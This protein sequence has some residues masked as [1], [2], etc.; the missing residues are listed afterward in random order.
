MSSVASITVQAT[1]DPNMKVYHTRFEMSSGP[2]AGSRGDD[3]QV[4]GFGQLVLAIQ[5][6]SQ[7]RVCPYILMVTKAPLFTWDEVEP[8]VVKLLK[9][10]GRSQLEL[11]TILSSKSDPR[12]TAQKECE[13]G[14]GAVGSATG[15]KKP[16]RPSARAIRENRYPC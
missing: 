5:G 12:L 13:E 8:N 15:V 3:E 2:E 16:R 9:E 7:V 1:T 11:E 10:F 14:H 6:V 4:G